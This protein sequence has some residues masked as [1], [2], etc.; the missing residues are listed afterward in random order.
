LVKKI[1]ILIFS[2]L[3]TTEATLAG[4][5]STS[6]VLRDKTIRMIER[7]LNAISKPIDEGVVD[8][9]SISS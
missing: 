4:D 3:T 9:E 5:I 1:R 6:A 8:A 2:S 7:Y